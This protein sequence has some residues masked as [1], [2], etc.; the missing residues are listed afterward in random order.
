MFADEVEGSRR[1]DFGNWVEI[2]AAEEDAEV[3]KLWMFQLDCSTAPQTWKD[4]TCL[5]SIASPAR[6]RSR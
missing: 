1:A 2:V 5:R 4:H 3:D 6:T